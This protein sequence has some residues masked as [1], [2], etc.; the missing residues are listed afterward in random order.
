MTTMLAL[1]RRPEGG[2]NALETFQRRDAEEGE[3]DVPESDTA[4]SPGVDTV[5][6]T[7]EERP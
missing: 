7:P 6:T 2:V 1:F 4:T 3:R 5:E